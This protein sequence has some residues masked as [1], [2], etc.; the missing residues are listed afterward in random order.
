MSK[1]PTELKSKAERRGR[2]AH[3]LERATERANKMNSVVDDLTAQLAALDQA[4]KTHSPLLE[5]RRIKIRAFSS[6]H[7]QMTVRSVVSHALKR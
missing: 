2:L 1:T 7:E 4:I 6:R 3:E 5:N